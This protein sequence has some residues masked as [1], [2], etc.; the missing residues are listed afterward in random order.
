MTHPTVSSVLTHSTKSRN[1]WRV[2]FVSTIPSSDVDEFTDTC[3]SNSGYTIYQLYLT[4]TLHRVNTD[5]PLIS[6]VLNSKMAY[7]SGICKSRVTDKTHE[8]LTEDSETAASIS[9]HRYRAVQ[10]AE[11]QFSKS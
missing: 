5:T 7:G 10:D 6:S 8:A 2:R 3:E 4:P 1:F 11:H 9:N